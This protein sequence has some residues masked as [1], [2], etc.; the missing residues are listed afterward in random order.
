MSDK[1]VT[2]TLTFED[3]QLLESLF[4]SQM[5]IYRD[6]DMMYGEPSGYTVGTSYD[7]NGILQGTRELTCREFE[8]WTESIMERID[9]AGQ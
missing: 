1:K 9:I 7:E 5:D 8:V 2:I 4:Q 6:A 3:R